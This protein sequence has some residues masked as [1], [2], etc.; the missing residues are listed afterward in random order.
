MDRRTPGASNC[1]FLQV[2]M[3]GLIE[4]FEANA[5][6]AA[7]TVER[8]GGS[9]AA[10][11]AA[12]LSAVKDSRNI[13]LDPGEFLPSQILD[14]LGEL[15]G[16]L[17]KPSDEALSTADAG[18]SSAFAGIASSGS[19]CIAMGPPLAAAA[20]LLMP[21]HV[22]LLCA[23]R[24]VERPRDLFEPASLGGEGLRRNLV[25]ITGPSATADM[26]PL[27]RGVHGPHRLR[28]FVLE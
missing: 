27:V 4:A 6:R 15:P 7:A 21:L 18:I 1:A 12:V 5:H 14:A 8:I 28:I 13:V 10:V 16:L 20:S 17:H 26:G 22:V 3:P 9:P 25:L 11:R 23:N 24:I 2:V 19:V